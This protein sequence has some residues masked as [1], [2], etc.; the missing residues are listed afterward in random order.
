MTK[1]PLIIYRLSWQV[2]FH[3]AGADRKSG[4]E[5]A[6]GQACTDE[7]SMPGDVLGSDSG[8]GTD[9]FSLPAQFNFPGLLRPVGLTP[10]PDEEDVWGMSFSQ[11][12]EISTKEVDLNGLRTGNKYHF[13]FPFQLVCPLMKVL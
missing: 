3:H 10:S 4:P 5:S 8:R 6:T 2:F 9:D 11:E 13:L 1:D 7:D 12:W